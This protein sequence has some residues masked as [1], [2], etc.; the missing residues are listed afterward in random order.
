[1]KNYINV[2]KLVATHGVKGALVM[3]HNLGKKTSFK[4]LKAI[5][6]EDLPG[7]FLPYFPLD[8]KIRQDDEVLLEVEGVITREKAATLVQ[9]QVWLEEADFKKYAAANAPISLLGFL[10]FD[11]D[12]ELGEV[13][14]V[15][16]QPHQVM[17]R[18]VID[19]H[20]ILIPVHEQSLKKID[21]KAK[22]VVLD[23]PEGLV[24]AQL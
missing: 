5:F 22:K 13:Q 24:E 1:M 20:D 14:E 7:S 17:L 23:L 10:V 21:K 3:K 9:K 19:K 15:I 12:K 18:V 4:G 11:K 6:I 8:I 2:G 16:E